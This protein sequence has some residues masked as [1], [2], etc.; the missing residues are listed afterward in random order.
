VGN[1]CAGQTLATPT[2]TN[3]RSGISRAL[4]SRRMENH[5]QL[6]DR[7]ILGRRRNLHFICM[8]WRA[9]PKFGDIRGATNRGNASGLVSPSLQISDSR[10]YHSAIVTHAC[11]AGP[12]R[13]EAGSRG[14][15]TRPE[16]QTTKRLTSHPFVSR[17]CPI[18][19]PVTTT[20]KASLLCARRS[21]KGAPINAGTRELQ[22][23]RPRR[24]Q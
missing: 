24:H 17:H 11:P 16:D 10:V 13:A 8:A 22:P 14:G 15:W 3:M 19:I 12:C 5:F 21:L 9:R 1:P 4:I 2:T 7:S 18:S 20:K 6:T 23:P